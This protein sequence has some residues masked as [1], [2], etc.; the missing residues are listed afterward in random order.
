MRTIRELLRLALSS[1]LGDRDI[2]RSLGVSHPTVKKYV[3]A[4]QSA[5]LDWAAIEQMDDTALQSIIK[6]SRGRK[7]DINRPLPDYAYVHQ[8]LKKRGVTLYLLWQEYKQSNPDG[9]KDTQFRKYYYDFAKKLDVTLRQH[10]KFGESLFV[11]YAGQTV[12]IY[13]RVTGAVTQ[14]QILWQFWAAATIP[15]PRQQRTKVY[16]R[17]QGRMCGVLNT[18]VEFRR[19]WYRT[20]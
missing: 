5:G 7:A 3:E 16:R 8:E 2:G 13:D 10:H 1:E 15:T 12:P 17:G 6:G 14:A 19:E 11:D 18:L 4:I 9:Y 20:I